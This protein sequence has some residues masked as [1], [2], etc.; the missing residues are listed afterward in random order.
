[1]GLIIQQLNVLS[2]QPLQRPKPSLLPR[3]ELLPL[4]KLMSPAAVLIGASA[5][6]APP[7]ASTHIPARSAEL[8]LMLPSTAWGDL[9]TAIPEEGGAKL[10]LPVLPPPPLNR[11][12]S[13]P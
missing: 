11:V 3:S 1:M 4:Q 8:T 10:H 9:R 7:L 6:R 5:T 13:Y 12:S 2:F